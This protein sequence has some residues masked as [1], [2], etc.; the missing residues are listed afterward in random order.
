MFLADDKIVFVCRGAKIPVKIVRSTHTVVD[1]K[2]G[3][4]YAKGGDSS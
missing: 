2:G 4:L 3:I 1:E